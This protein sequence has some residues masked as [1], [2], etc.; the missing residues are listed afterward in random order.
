MN[1]VSRKRVQARKDIIRRAQ[2]KDV[3][4][5]YNYTY[6]HTIVK[7]SKEASVRPENEP[8]TESYDTTTYDINDINRQAQEE[9]VRLPYVT[10]TYDINDINGIIG[11]E[12]EVFE[13]F[14]ELKPREEEE[15]VAGV[16]TSFHAEPEAREEEKRVA[17]VE[18]YIRDKLEGLGRIRLGLLRLVYRDEGGDPS[19]LLPAARRMGCRIERFAEYQ[20]K[21]FVLPP[22]VLHTTDEPVHRATEPFAWEGEDL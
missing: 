10:T 22:D 5:F 21:E 7:E 8:E 19:L 9:D 1:V 13:F 11:S 18:G 20:D 2:E 12:A 15:R 17:D 6:K 14:R 3:K 16:D 4:E